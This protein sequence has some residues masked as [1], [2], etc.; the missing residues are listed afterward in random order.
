MSTLKQER[1]MVKENKALK[2]QIDHLESKVAFL[3]ADILER[4]ANFMTQTQIF[5]GMLRAALDEAGTIQEA[6]RWYK[7]WVKDINGIDIEALD[8][9]QQI[10]KVIDK[11]GFDITIANHADQVMDIWAKD[12]QQANLKNGAQA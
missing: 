2:K 10:Q 7:E 12:R 6:R 5:E 4:T 1:A 9:N 11:H 3:K 8:H